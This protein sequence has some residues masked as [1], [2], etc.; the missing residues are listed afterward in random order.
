MEIKEKEIIVVKDGEEYRLVKKADIQELIDQLNE[1]PVWAMGMNWLRQQTGG[2]SPDWLKDNILYP[3]RDELEDI[4][5]YPE[6]GETW[7]F[8]IKEVKKWLNKKGN[9]RKVHR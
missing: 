8:H 2:R 6:N 1:Q 3:H 7:S 4:V 5:S 9:F